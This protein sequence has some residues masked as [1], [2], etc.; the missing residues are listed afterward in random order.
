MGI[1]PD[2]AWPTERGAKS[3][4]DLLGTVWRGA[5]IFIAFGRN[6]LKSPDSKK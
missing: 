4:R 1:N 3:I 6:S 5:K 2:L